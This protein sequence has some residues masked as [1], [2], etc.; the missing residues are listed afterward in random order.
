MCMGKTYLMCQP[1]IRVKSGSLG[2]PTAST[3]YSAPRPKLLTKRCAG[4]LKEIKEL[5]IVISRNTNTA[6]CQLNSG[7]PL[8]AVLD[9]LSRKGVQPRSILQRFQCRSI[10]G[11]LI[12]MPV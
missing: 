7:E 6:P 5:E 3:R 1:P 2:K 9:D 11:M 12:F 8:Q 4:A 10:P